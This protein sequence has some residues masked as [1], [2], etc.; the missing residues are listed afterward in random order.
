M[1]LHS[2]RLMMGMTDQGNERSV[3]YVIGVSLLM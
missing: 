2:E 1:G 3:M